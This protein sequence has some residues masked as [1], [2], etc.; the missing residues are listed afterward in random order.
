MR[1]HKGIKLWCLVGVLA[2]APSWAG[3]TL[4]TAIG[5]GAGGVAGAILGQ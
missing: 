5:G 2:A 1:G 3:Q 4:N